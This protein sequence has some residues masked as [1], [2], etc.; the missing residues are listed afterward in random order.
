[1]Y[2]EYS[3]NVAAASQLGLGQA[4]DINPTLAENIEGKINY[5]RQ[6]IERLEKIKGQID[7]RMLEMNLRDLREAMS[8]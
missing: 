7:P 1:M 4:R 6:E 5:H 8:F 3:N 2:D